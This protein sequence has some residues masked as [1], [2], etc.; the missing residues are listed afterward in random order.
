MPALTSACVLQHARYLAPVYGG[1]CLAYTH[2][3]PI[4]GFFDA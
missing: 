3:I 1:F 2:G 4:S